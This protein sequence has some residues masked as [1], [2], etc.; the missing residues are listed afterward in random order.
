MGITDKLAPDLNWPR[1]WE[2]LSR[3]VDIL[4]SRV[5][6]HP[7]VLPLREEFADVLGRRL[8]SCSDLEA[9]RFSAVIDPIVDAVAHEW[10]QMFMEWVGKRRDYIFPDA[11]S[12]VFL[13]R[14]LWANEALLYRGHYDSRWRLTSS[15]RRMSGANPE[16]AV[17]ERNRGAVFLERLGRLECVK[18]AYFSGIPPHHEE[19]ILQHYG[20]PTSLIDMTYS[21]DVAIYFG[22]GGDHFDPG[23]SYRPE[24]GAL[25]VFPTWSLPTSTRLVTLPPAIMRPTLQRGVFLSDISDSETSRL[26]SLKFVFRHHGLPV[27]NGLTGIP[28]GAPV[29]LTRYLFPASDEIASVLQTLD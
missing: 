7:A 5:G 29:N 8:V 9:R 6:L 26:E 11:F 22:E 24:T 2:L 17:R 13:T 23:P 12:A 19:A 15:W 3:C 27:W 10:I 1:D 28:F 14:G 4:W 25:Y 21:S 16:D 20:F 18:A